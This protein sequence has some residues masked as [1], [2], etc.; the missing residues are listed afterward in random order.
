MRNPQ[1]AIN[2]GGPVTHGLP[3]GRPLRL[4][5]LLHLSSTGTGG[6]ELESD[7]ALGLNPVYTRLVEFWLVSLNNQN[8]VTYHI[9]RNSINLLN[10]P[11]QGM[12]VNTDK[13]VEQGKYV[14]LKELTV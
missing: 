3:I 11:E 4:L 2:P 10:S 1:R 8:S 9:D 14:R 7:D 13:L 6:D 5:G 12:V